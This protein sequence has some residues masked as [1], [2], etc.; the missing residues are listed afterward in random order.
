MTAVMIE[1]DFILFKVIF[2]T[3]IHK[4]QVSLCLTFCYAKLSA[5]Y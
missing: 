1:H 5:K 4:D 2:T 3:S